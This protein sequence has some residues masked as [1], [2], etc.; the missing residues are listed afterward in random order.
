GFAGLIK[1]VKALENHVIPPMAKGYFEK[2]NPLI[3]LSSSPF[4]IASELQNF[5]IKKTMY[6]GVSSFGIGGT[7]GHCILAVYNIESSDFKDKMSSIT[8]NTRNTENTRVIL[9]FSAKSINSLNNIK[10]QFK[11]YFKNY[12]LTKRNMYNL[13]NI[14]RTLQM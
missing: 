8:E 13:C 14:A 3:N 7:N 6:A 11:N 12:N 4:Y 5:N 9:P 1:T 2:A 10:N